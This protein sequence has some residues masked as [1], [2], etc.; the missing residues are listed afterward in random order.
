MNQKTKILIFILSFCLCVSCAVAIEKSSDFIKTASSG[1]ANE[2]ILI[3][4][5]GHGNFDGGAVA[6][7]G[8]VEKHLNLN[9]AHHLETICK[10]NG[11]SVIMVRKDDT[12]LEDDSNASIR[13]RKNSDL[14][15]RVALMEKFPNSIYVSIHMNKFSDTSVH[16]AQIFYTTNFDNAKLLAEKLRDYVN[17]FDENN[18]KEIKKGTKDAY[19][20][21]QAKCPA[22]IYEC[23]FMSNQSELTKLKDYTYQRK[24]AFSIYLGLIEYFNTKE[25]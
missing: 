10:S 17:L 2:S 15:N 9:I 14:H 19:I 1:V 6:S 20:L 22:V 12:S 24:I 11:L 25:N 5:A 23:G 21:Y 16:G 18:N 13:N 7:D 8:T 3:I 4:D